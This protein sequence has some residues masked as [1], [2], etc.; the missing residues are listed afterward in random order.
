VVARE[1]EAAEVASPVLHDDL[2]ARVEEEEDVD[3]P[4]FW[5]DM[6]AIAAMMAFLLLSAAVSM[7]SRTGVG[8][9]CRGGAITPFRAILNSIS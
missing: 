3:G 4:E 6:P 8:E 1:E 7:G 9:G 5:S 2:E